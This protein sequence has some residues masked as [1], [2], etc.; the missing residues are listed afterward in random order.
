M[1]TLNKAREIAQNIPK[2]TERPHAELEV[3][4]TQELSTKLYHLAS[5]IANSSQKASEDLGTLRGAIDAVVKSMDKSTETMASLTHWLIA[6]AA[7]SAVAA[8]IQVILFVA[9]K[10]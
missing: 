7:V 5:V 9:K 10:G 1:E 2:P 4:L 8:I 6:A 3:E